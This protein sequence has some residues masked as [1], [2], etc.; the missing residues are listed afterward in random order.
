LNGGRSA[1]LRRLIQSADIGGG[2]TVGVAEAR[3]DG[4]RT[5]VQLAPADAAALD[6]EAAAM[7]LARASWLAA[8]VRRRVRGRTMF[9]P[10]DAGSLLAIQTE[11][12]RI[13]VSVNQIARA[14]DTAVLEGRVVELELSDLT[15]FRLE[16]RGHLAALRQA[17]E[18]NLAYWAVD[19]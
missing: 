2:E 4:A 19:P 18:G 14:L 1:L 3:R 13:G 10:R 9:S 11:L 12:R 7:G 15:A 6:A 8:L 17:F 5:T 16:L